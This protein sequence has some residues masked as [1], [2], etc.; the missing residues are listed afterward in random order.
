MPHS[1]S[2]NARTTAAQLCPIRTT[3]HRFCILLNHF[4][5]FR[6]KTLLKS[7]WIPH[8]LNKIEAR[9][10]LTQIHFQIVPVMSPASGA[11]TPIDG[12]IVAFV[13][14][15]AADGVA[16]VVAPTA[17]VRVREH[18]VIFLVVADG[19]VAAIR[20]RQVVVLSTETTIRTC[21]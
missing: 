17:D 12:H 5:T 11:I 9:R 7:R 14:V 2:T 13:V 19:T 8:I 21:H 1:P 20:A 3:R 18:L 6:T 10:P 15:G 4:A 16:S